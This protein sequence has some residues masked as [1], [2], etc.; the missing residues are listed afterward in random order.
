MRSARFGAVSHLISS[1][2][3]WYHVLILSEDTGLEC[4]T[5]QQA[6]RKSQSLQK[7]RPE[8][9]T[10]KIVILMHDFS[11]TLAKINK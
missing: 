9:L 6:A 1:Q 5:L 8:S 3:A 2:I 4:L 11:W 7:L 10:V